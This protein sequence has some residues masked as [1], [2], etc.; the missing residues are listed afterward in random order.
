MQLLK[1]AIDKEDE[2]EEVA[3]SE[4]DDDLYSAGDYLGNDFTTTNG[5]RNSQK[6]TAASR[7]TSESRNVGSLLAKA[8]RG[9]GSISRISDGSGISYH[10]Q[11][12]E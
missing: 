7:S 4:D 3:T 9:R 5:T 8:R 1:T 10:E 2:A 11:R 6:T 12:R